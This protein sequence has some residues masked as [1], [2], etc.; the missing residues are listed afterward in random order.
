M[1]KN[2]ILTASLLAPL[3]FHWRCVGSDGGG[4]HLCTF[5]GAWGT[6]GVVLCPG[7]YLV[8]GLGDGLSAD[9]RKAGR[10]Q[11]FKSLKGGIGDLCS[12]FRLDHDG[13]AS[14]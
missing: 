14:A 9:P 8:G 6:A 5:L 10:T 11:V 3:I 13:L 7:D 12:R 1:L 2:R 4:A